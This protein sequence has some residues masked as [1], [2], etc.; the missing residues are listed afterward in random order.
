MH[1]TG[2]TLARARADLLLALTAVQASRGHLQVASTGLRDAERLYQDVGARGLRAA[3]LANLA[4]VELGQGESSA[5]W[6][7]G[8]AAL[9]E[10]RA[11]G[12][13]PGEVAALRILGAAALQ[14]G[15]LEE[16]SRHLELARERAKELE[17]GTEL[18]AIHYLVARVRL[19]AG[20]ARAALRALDL[21]QLD[22]K[23]GDPEHYLPAI[24]AARACSL[25]LVGEPEA[26][27]AAIAMAEAALVG[28]PALWRAQATLEVAQA[29]VYLG[30]AERGLALALSAGQAATVRGFRMLA[31]ESLVLAAAACPDPAERARLLAEARRMQT[32]MAA[33][34]PARWAPAFR[35]RP[36]FEAS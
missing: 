11:S 22:A 1:A 7:H 30:D 27:R 8:S 35:S 21:A 34:L 4:E 26:A 13:G 24:A 9:E 3:A 36:G 5:A 32:A 16:A 31:L 33:A 29:H 20:E 19:A 25:A 15:D 18:V 17:I 6:Q 12:R 10:A 23:D 28:L 2:P 14:L